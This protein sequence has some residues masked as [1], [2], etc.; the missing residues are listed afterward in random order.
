VP[1]RRPRRRGGGASLAALLAGCTAA[2]GDGATA[3]TPAPPAEAP[4]LADAPAPR[5]P[6]ARGLPAFPG[7]EGFGAHATGGRGGRVLQVTNLETHGPGS[8]QAALDEAGPRTIVFRV[9]GVIPGAVRISSGDVTIA[10]QTSPGGI[11]VRGLHTTE[12]PYC[13]QSCGPKLDGVDNFVIRHLRSR[14]AGGEF[15]DGLRLRY[16]RNG[17]VDHLSIANASDEAVEISYASDLTIQY[18][19]LAET[20]GEHANLGGMLINYSNPEAGYELTRLSIHHNLWNRVDG[21]MPELSRESPAA[22]GSTMQI[23]LSNNLLWDP[24]YYIDLNASTISGSADG[25]PIFY[26]LNWVG[27]RA[28]ARADFPYGMIWLPNPHGRSSAYFADDELSVAPGRRDFQLLY[29]CNDFQSA[30]PPAPPAWAR[31]E[32][33]PFPPIAYTPGAALQEHLL[34][35]VGCFP[36]DLMDRRLLAPLR[37]GRI[38]ET[39]RSINPAGDAL[40]TLPAPAPPLDTDADGMPDAWEAGHG[41][42]PRVQDHNDTHL[43]LSLLGV[44]GYTNLECYL[45]ELAEQR[46]RA[47]P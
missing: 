28:V 38:A 46:L 26:E 27:N 20:L 30:P 18:T 45:H 11:T 16:A 4:G 43:S 42:D 41:L 3:P 6:A 10:G 2:P 33:H 1:P 22:A 15:P 5:P 47:D 35:R 17:I 8:L 25:A 32:R 9:S 39:L 13:D 24:G 23:E 37:R 34:E 40:R 14:P 29:C 12:D 36:R 7:A 31:G 21:R 19:M 44:A